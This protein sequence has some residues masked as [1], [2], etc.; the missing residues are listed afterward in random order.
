MNKDKEL[1]NYL[2]ISPYKFGIYLFNS[3]SLENLYKEELAVN[4]NG[5]ILNLSDLKKFLDKNIF[6][7]EK[8]N[9]KFV[10]NIVLIYEDKNIFNVKFGIK[11]KNYNYS[12][13]KKYLENLLIEAKDLFKENYQDQ[14]IMHMTINKY[15][16]NDQSFLSFKENL[17]CDN[18]SLEIQF[19]S[20][21]NNIFYDL[22]KILENYQ[23]KIT[24]CLDLNYLKNI[25]R[26]NEEIS[27]M[28]YKVLNGYNQNEVIFVP[29]N[30]KKL[31]F[32]EKFFQLFS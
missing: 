29:K 11:K 26:E 4:E 27:E 28:S 23:I 2:R 18:F 12:I 9:R 30:P 32:F 13:S 15:F 19:T 24:R 31:P 5:T 10:E 8:L 6:K 16:F 22:N 20:I 21:S 7:I 14:K 25:F 17:T 3:N 1:E